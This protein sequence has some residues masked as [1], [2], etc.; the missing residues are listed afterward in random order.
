MRISRLQ[1]PRALGT[2]ELNKG[3]G[4]NP[5]HSLRTDVQCVLARTLQEPFIYSGEANA[6]W[7]SPE[8]FPMSRFSGKTGSVLNS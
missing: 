3:S 7:N 4:N 6:L 1:I 8:T 5:Q 2:P